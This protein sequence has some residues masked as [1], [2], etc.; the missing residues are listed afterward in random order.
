VR[1]CHIT[2][3]LPPEQA[4]NA[5]LPYHLGCWARDAGDEVSY[6]AHPPRAA[7]APRSL[8]DRPGPVAWV[9]PYRGGALGRLSRLSSLVTASRIARAAR[10]P[11]E[12][13]DVVHVHGNGLLAEVAA[14]MATRLGKPYVLTLYGT[15]IWHYRPRR[16]GPDLFTRAYRGAA[17]VTFYSHGLQAR[18]VELG[19]ARHQASV[20]YPP[21]APEFTFRDAGQQADARRALGIRQRHVLVNV[22]RLHPLAGQ[23]YLLEAMGE[24]I[25]THPDTRLII[26][27][28]GALLEE[29][30]DVARTNGVERHVTF[31]GLLDNQEVAQYD[32]AAD[33]FVLPSLLEACPTVALEALATG[34]PVI[35]SDN[36][37]GVELQEIFG[38]DVTIVP[39]ENA[40]ALAQAIVTLLDG[41]RRVREPTLRIIAQEFRPAAVNRQ[42]R[43]I[44]GSVLP[45]A[46]AP[47]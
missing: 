37:G 40:M 45:G 34:T 2:P 3:H 42:F 44:Y 27:G 8:G 6:V 15:E 41:S 39:R 38:Y 32:A 9:E 31:T 47:S 24:V 4:A 22:K 33:A 14:W 19:L 29:L 35:S 18:A 1:I 30:K 20:V 7:S 5:L 12:A 25:R 17:H 11:I 26:C 36:P 21:V 46:G 43:D 16:V 13:A 23:R 10:A 28:T